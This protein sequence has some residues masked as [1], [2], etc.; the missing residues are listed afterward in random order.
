MTDKQF[1]MK[2][3]Q[4]SM[5]KD[6]AH[7]VF[8]AARIIQQAYDEDLGIIIGC[9]R[10]KDD[11]SE[12]RQLYSAF[13]AANVDDKGVRHLLCY[14]SR[15][16]AESDKSLPEPWEKVKLR[17]II[18]NMLNKPSI[19]GL[20][21]NHHDENR[22]LLIPKLCFVQT[23]EAF[24]DELKHITNK[25]IE[26]MPEEEMQKMIEALTETESGPKE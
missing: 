6:K 21:F 13:H 5:K 1:W 16:M 18:D 17:D 3:D 7:V 11:P 4:L 10:D 14:T 8:E 20:L 24:A 12:V 23:E 25:M 9:V 15:K 22:M 26:N 19:G 2:L